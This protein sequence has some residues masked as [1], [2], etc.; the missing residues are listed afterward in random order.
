MITDDMIHGP[1]ARPSRRRIQNDT[2]IV[3]RAV[4]EA[5]WQ[6]AS[7]YLQ[8]ELPRAWVRR[9]AIRANMVY[10]RNAQ[11]RVLLR[12]DGEAGRDW[13]WAFTRH[14]LAALI[15]KHH[16]DL[17]AQLPGDYNTGR[18]LPARRSFCSN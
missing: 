9:L 1:I 12:K 10:Q 8:A 14:W 5:V 7:V 13:L 16:P 17:H 4:A 11:F 6:E 2:P 18:E 15:A 3:P